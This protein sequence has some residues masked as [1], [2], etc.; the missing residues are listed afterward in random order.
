MRNGVNANTNNYNQG[1]ANENENQAKRRKN[2]VD[3][4]RGLQEPWEW[5]DK[6][7]RR[8]RNK[9]LL[10]KATIHPDNEVVHNPVGLFTADQNLK[11]NN[12]LGISAAIYTRQNPNGNR[13]GYECPE[14]RDYFPYWHPT[15]WKDIAVLAVNRSM[16]SYYQSKSFNVQPYHECV[17]YW[18]AAKTRRKWYSKWN[19][20]QECVDN[21]GDWRLL[22]NYLEKLPGKGTQ[23]ACESSSANG[24]V[25]KWAVPYDSADA[26]TA[27]C[28][29]LLDAPECKEAPWTRSNHLGN[30]RDG[31]ASSYDWTLPYFP[32]SK[33]QRCALRIRYNISTDDYDPY[34]T[35]SSSN[36]NSAPGVQSP[37]RQNPYV[38]I[39]AY[40]VPLRL[41]I[42][43]AQF[44]RTFQDRSHI[45][46]LRQRPSGHDT[47][48]I[49]NL[50][51]RGKRGNIVQ[52]YPAV[53]YDFAP[54]TLDIKADDLVH[55]QWTG[56]NTHNNGNPAGDGQA[57]DAG[58]GQGGT[59]RNNLVQ[60]VSLNDNFPLP[61]E[62]TD[63][64]TK[65]K[66][67]WIYHGKS[68]KSEDLAISMASSGYYMCV[69]ANQCPVPS[70]SAQNKAALNNL[71]NNA[72]ASY[73][74]ALLKFERG[75][76]VYLCTR[77]NNFTNRSQKGKLIVR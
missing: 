47:R 29:V 50:N 68:V 22:H 66:A 16:C 11:N 40:N 51:V 32:S 39:G 27:E 24:I 41:A 4:N 8:E 10:T 33:T 26:K 67:V 45:F 55:I 3:I 57:G 14:E 77:N 31:N 76:Y 70:E 58:E 42:N 12:G 5:Y 49:Y 37:V 30:S 38:D 72:P 7:N 54:N 74:G 59:D 19:N 21:G 9:G 6:C 35:D 44:G 53:E 62:N 13:R 73:E 20:R 1:N 15:P 43:T 28:L 65:S 18:D 25:Q 2:N 48:R 52:T 75:E 60:A 34:K 63:M 17:E 56:S 46:K 64:W 36:Q 69:T 61:Y 71:L 23:R